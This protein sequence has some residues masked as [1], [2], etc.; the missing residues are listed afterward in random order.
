MRRAHKLTLCLLLLN[1]GDVRALRAEEFQI[2]I[3]DFYGRHR[4]TEE[5]VRQA[6]TFK[7]GDTI[8]LAGDE[9]PALFVA[10]ESRLGALPAIVRAHTNFVCCDAGRAIIYVGIE[11]KGQATLHF[12]S[13]PRGNVRLPADI[14][15]AGHEFSQAFAAAMQRG[16]NVEDDSQGHSL[17]HD[18][19]TRAVQ[20]RFVGYATRNLI[21]LRRV[22]HESSDATQRSLAAQILGYVTNKQ[23][24]V[25]DLVYG[26][27]DPSDEVRNNA[28][29]ALAVFANVPST[30]AR[31]MVRVPYEPF[32]RLLN[33]L[34]W[35]D[36]NKAS[37]ALMGLSE[38]RDPALLRK[39]RGEAMAALI[40]IAH[41]KS[42]GHAFPALMLLGRIAGQSDDATQ[43]ALTRG[44]RE[45]IIVEALKRH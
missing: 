34:A 2:G 4:V 42:E 37:W 21:D 32:I 7:E 41:W 18:P 8:S 30:G 20:E 31:P 26:M 16:D 33:S 36:R 19:A 24:I 9:P 35:T 45:S 43:A 28:M 14:L 15:Q 38:R 6:L 17:A 11:E 23:N 44:E 29:R 40:E 27:S 13:A 5:E 10:S 12:R 22:L 1:L 3:I 25:E 39:L